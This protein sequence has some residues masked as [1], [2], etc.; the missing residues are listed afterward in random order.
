MPIFMGKTLIFLYEMPIFMGK[1]LIFPCKMLIFKGKTLIFL[2]K[3]P[4]I[5]GLPASLLLLEEGWVGVHMTA[6]YNPFSTK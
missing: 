6:A 1:T 5:F 2:F 3:I 4:I